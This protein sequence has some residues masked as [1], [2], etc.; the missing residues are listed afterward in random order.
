[1]TG[2]KLRDS[3]HGA[4]RLFARVTGGKD[5][6][7]TCWMLFSSHTGFC[8]VFCLHISQGP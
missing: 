4:E 5:R 7:E 3:A 8:F 6:I 2:A 1:M